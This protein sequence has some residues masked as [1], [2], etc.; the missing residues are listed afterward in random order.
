MQTVPPG[1]SV[2]RLLYAA[3]F[4]SF[5]GWFSAKPSFVTVLMVSYTGVSSSPCSFMTTGSGN[6]RCLQMHKI[7]R[8]ESSRNPP[9]TGP[10]I[11]SAAPAP[12]TRSCTAVEFC[13]PCSFGPRSGTGPCGSQS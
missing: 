4:R 9:T 5:L 7:N 3:S 11:H 13:L 6:F 2:L 1:F 10:Q 12:C 8:L